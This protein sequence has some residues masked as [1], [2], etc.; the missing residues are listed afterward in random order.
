VW[1]WFSRGSSGLQWAAAFCFWS[2]V[3]HICLSTPHWWTS[4]LRPGLAIV[5]NAAL[6]T[7]WRSVCVKTRFPPCPE[8]AGTGALVTGVL[9]SIWG[10]AR[11]FSRAFTSCPHHQ[12]QGLRP[13]HLLHTK[14]PLL[15]HSHPGCTK[16]YLREYG[17]TIRRQWQQAAFHPLTSRLFTLHGEMPIYAILCPVL[18][19]DQLSFSRR[20]LQMLLTSWTLASSFLRYTICRTFSHLGVACLC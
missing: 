18:K 8:H 14:S 9:F 12:C 13:L 2:R 20:T 7:G 4:E 5:G 19:M 17:V 3:H 11:R 10:T 16:R 6:R 15:S 1:P